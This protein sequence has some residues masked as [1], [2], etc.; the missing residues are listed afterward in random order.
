MAPIVVRGEEL[1]GDPATRP[2]GA[3]GALLINFGETVALPSEIRKL[4][5]AVLTMAV[6]DRATSVHYHPWR[7]DGRLTYV[8]EG[9]QRYEFIPPPEVHAV[10]II[11]GARSLFT[12]PPARGLLSLFVQRAPEPAVC[13]SFTFEVGGWS[14]VWDAVCWSNGERA[15]VELI[16]VTPLE[17]PRDPQQ[18][19]S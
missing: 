14:V 4:W 15:S 12:A 8:I 9:R 1:L 6:R 5:G 16:R 19:S 10:T 3:N 13:S 18:S 2:S 7:T 17:Q 11:E